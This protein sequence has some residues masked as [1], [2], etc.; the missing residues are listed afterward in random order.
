MTI[1]TVA[2]PETLFAADAP[3]APPRLAAVCDGVLLEVAPTEAAQ[4]EVVRVLSTD[5]ADFLDAALQPGSR[6][7]FEP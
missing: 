7:P 4:C 5:P 1:W 6:L 3:A 2:S